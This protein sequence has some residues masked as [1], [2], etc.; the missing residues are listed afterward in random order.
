MTRYN[1]GD[2]DRTFTRHH[3]MMRHKMWKH[4]DKQDA[5]E[6]TSNDSASQISIST[7]DSASQV[8]DM[9][10]HTTSLIEN[11]DIFGADQT[12]KTNL[13]DELRASVMDEYN[14]EISE[15]V[16]SVMKSEGISKR[17]AKSV[18]LPKWLPFVQKA[19]YKAYFNE[20]CFHQKMKKDSL[21]NKIINV[22]RKIGLEDDN[23]D[24]EEDLRQ[25]IKRKKY[26]I[27]K[28]TRLREEDILPS[29]EE[30]DEVETG[31]EEDSSE[32]EDDKAEPET[33]SSGD[34]KI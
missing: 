18:V 21:H 22:K 8:T 16:H 3:D 9:C 30:D 34:E 14:D 5:D 7:K 11:K 26:A 25:A 24:D 12:E 23:E 6:I 29:G 4:K 32:E 10:S 13:W 33:G 1:C 15:D 17:K 28:A 2:C 27:Q 20:V 31:S 19:I